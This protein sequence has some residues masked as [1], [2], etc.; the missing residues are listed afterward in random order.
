M[1]R[2]VMVSVAM[3]ALLLLGTAIWWPGRTAPAASQTPG[4]EERVLQL[5][6]RLTAVEAR[7]AAL[8][9]FVPAVR[10]A[11]AAELEAY[12]GEL[13][14][15]TQAYSDYRQRVDA[16]AGDTATLQTLAAEGTALYRALS[17]RIRALVPP[18][19]YATVQ[20]LLIQAANLFDAVVTFGVGTPAV[21]MTENVLAA[22]LSQAQQ[23]FAAARC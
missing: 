19:C 22:T 16:A 18:P 8:E 12:R 4:L 5:E 3:L 9:M 2:R 11:P 15:I 23:V 13:L 1:Q 17:L 21:T 14:A 10:P 6:A 20:V 7:L